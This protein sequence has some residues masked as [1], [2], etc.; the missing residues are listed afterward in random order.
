MARE[1]PELQ[2]VENHLPRHHPGS[3]F[4]AG[5]VLRPRDSERGSDSDLA[6]LYAPLILDGDENT[7]DVAAAV[8]SDLPLVRAN[9]ITSLDGSVTGSDGKSG[10]INGPADLRVFQL[11]RAQSDAVFV[12]AGT[13]RI[14]GYQDTDIAAGLQNLRDDSN[15]K[16]ITITRSGELAPEFLETEPL[17]ITASRQ[18][19][20]Q[21]LAGQIPDE[22]LLVYGADAVD[23][24][25][26][27]RGL[28]ERGYEN[29][30]CEGGP[31]LMGSLIEKRLVSELC[32]S[33]SPMIVGGT[34]PRFMVGALT[35][36]RAKLQLLLSAPDGYLMSR[37]ALNRG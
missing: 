34:G 11:L 5:Y 3:Q 10:S 20:A 29:V 14:E 8:D 22:N 7:G 21:K 15:P 23:L 35:D 30:L 19:A 4:R 28:K 33:F 2:V 36:T 9:F 37:W 27:M 18:P 6:A 13:A 12:G 25:G 24:P 1:L 32:L 16:M 26:A 17:V 31:H